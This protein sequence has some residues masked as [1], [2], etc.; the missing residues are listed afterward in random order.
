MKDDAA[1]GIVRFEIKDEVNDGRR[2]K[3]KK[4]AESEDENAYRASA[5]GKL[6]RIKSGNI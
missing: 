5:G 1:I 4:K 2:Q 3:V 6:K